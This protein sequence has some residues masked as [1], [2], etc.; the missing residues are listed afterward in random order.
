MH[1]IRFR[2]W[3]HE[4]KGMLY[5]PTLQI[6][7]LHEAIYFPDRKNPTWTLMQFTG[8]LDKTGKEIYEGDIQK[9]TT[10]VFAVIV[11]DEKSAAFQSQRIGDDKRTS[12]LFG[13]EM[14]EV[15]GNIYENPELLGA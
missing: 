12:H 14:F 4:T 5:A 2:A 1:P 6:R 15:I 13:A 11:W 7:A 8:L 10:D 9:L 3:N